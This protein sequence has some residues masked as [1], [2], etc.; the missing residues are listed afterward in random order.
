MSACAPISAGERLYTQ[1]DFYRL[2]DL[3]ACDIVQPDL[4]HCGGI[5]AAKKIAAMAAAQDLTIAP[6][7]SIGP[8][9]LAV[10]VMALVVTA[11][12]PWARG[13]VPEMRTWILAYPAYLALVL[14]PFTSIFRYALPL[15]P[16]AVVLIG[17]THGTGPSRR[18]HGWVVTWVV[19]GVLG[20]IVWVRELLVFVPPSDYPP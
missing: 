5:L 19:L 10:L 18:R 16:I 13:L 6:H 12:G 1:S 2:I 11:L 8:V 3:R 9:A 15:F 7:C 17:G 14:D 4:A 20:Q